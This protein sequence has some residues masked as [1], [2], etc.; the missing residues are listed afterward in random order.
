MTRDENG[1]DGGEG[2][3][4]TSGY[5]E[6]SDISGLAPL[7]WRLAS[8]KLPLYERHL[9]SLCAYGFSAPLASWVRTRLEWTFDNGMLDEPD[10]V[11]VLSVNDKDLVDIT[12]E[13]ARD[14]P[15]DVASQGVIWTVCDGDLIYLS[16]ELVDATA[17]L[18]RDLASTLGYTVR[19]AADDDGDPTETFITCD[20]FGIVCCDDAPGPVARRMVEC[21]D[22]LWSLD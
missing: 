4:P 6:P 14:V 3:E 13:P 16:D 12:S 1:H 10:G 21:F 11:L 19:G 17:T 18:T 5:G 8:G 15:D 22:K 20:E 7:R 2:G 9:R